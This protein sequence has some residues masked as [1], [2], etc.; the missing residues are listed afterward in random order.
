MPVTAL[1]SA[2]LVLA[3][4]S[5]GC[6]FGIDVIVA[7]RCPFTGTASLRTWQAAGALALLA[8]AVA[9]LDGYVR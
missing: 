3:G 9:V 7:N 5:I 8:A 2:A 1:L 4:A 6:A